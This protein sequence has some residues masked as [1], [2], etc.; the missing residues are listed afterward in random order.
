M[1]AAF[2]LPLPV[3]VIAVRHY[4][5]DEH[6]VARKQHP[7]DEAILVATDVENDATADVTGGGEILLN[8]VPTLPIDRAVADVSI[9]S[10]QRSCGV[11][12]AGGLPKLNQ[13]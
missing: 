13:T 7:C 10:P 6:L 12:A 2:C 1:A 8:V 3:V 4:L 9:P 11:L 5:E